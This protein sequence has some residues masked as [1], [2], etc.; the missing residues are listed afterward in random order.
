MTPTTRAGR[1]YSKIWRELFGFDSSP[2]ILT[3]ETQARADAKGEIERLRRE[4]RALVRALIE[5]H[6]GRHGAHFGHCDA[7]YCG[8][9]A[10]LRDRTDGYNDDPLSARIVPE[11]T[12][13]R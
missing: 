12:D 7:G 3:I 11:P 8:R 13:G 9:V 10:Y 6:A 4:K 5:S 2:A 1:H